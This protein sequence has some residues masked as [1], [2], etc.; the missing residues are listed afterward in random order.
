MSESEKPVA[1]QLVSENKF[2]CVCFFCGKHSTDNA[3]VEIN[4][5]TQSIAFLCPACKKTN[6]MDLKSDKAKPYPRARLMR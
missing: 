4:F 2:M 6:T 3:V 1:E 5:I